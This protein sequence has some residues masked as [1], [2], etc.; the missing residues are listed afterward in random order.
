MFWWAFIR[1]GGGGGGGN[2]AEVQYEHLTILSFVSS[3]C[4]DITVIADFFPSTALRGAD[5]N[6][7]DGK[8]GVGAGVTIS[9]FD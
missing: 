5:Q 7:K 4:P 1:R 8:R 3:A 6:R 2:G 9:P